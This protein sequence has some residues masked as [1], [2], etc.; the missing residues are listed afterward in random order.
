MPTRNK[1]DK[2][3]AIYEALKA[4]KEH[5]SAE[6]LYEAM[7]EKVPGIG[8]ATV[9]RNLNL[10]LEDGMAISVGFVNGKERFDANCMPHT[11]FIC[12]KCGTVIDCDDIDPAEIKVELMEKYGAE[13]N[14]M[15]LRGLCALCNK[16][17]SDG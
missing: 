16:K 14:S 15:V 3:N 7:R 5:P 13:A 1:S 4:T 8:L 11:H 10:F 17:V 6:T 2:R 9:Y 12:E